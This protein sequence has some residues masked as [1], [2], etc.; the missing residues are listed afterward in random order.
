MYKQSARKLSITYSYPIR[1]LGVPQPLLIVR[2]DEACG[3]KR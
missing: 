1:T 2:I 3:G